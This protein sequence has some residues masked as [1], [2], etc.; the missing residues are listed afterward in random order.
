MRVSALLYTL[1]AAGMRC[2]TLRCMPLQVRS[3]ALRRIH[4]AHNI[5]VYR[6]ACMERSAHGVQLSRSA[7]AHCTA[8]RNARSAYMERSAHAWGAAQP[9]HI[10]ALRAAAQP[11][12]LRT[13]WELQTAHAVPAVC[14][15]LCAARA[16]THARCAPVSA[17]LYTL[18]AVL[19]VCDTAQCAACPCMLQVRSAAL[20]R[21]YMQ[22]TKVRYPSIPSKKI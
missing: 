17:L 18:C 6:K 8:Q 21:I 16:A 4:A 20:R 11:T 15:A 2:G 10:C 12:A 14:S 22:R 13:K 7:H 19:H 1:C 3:A 5:K 9:Q